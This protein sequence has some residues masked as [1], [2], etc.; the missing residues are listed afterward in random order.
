MDAGEFSDANADASIDMNLVLVTIRGDCYE[1]VYRR[2]HEY[3]GEGKDRY[4]STMR[5][6]RG[7]SVT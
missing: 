3:K 5:N 2:V 6:R 4:E 1:V 7:S